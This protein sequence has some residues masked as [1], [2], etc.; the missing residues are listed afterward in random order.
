VVEQRPFKHP[1]APKNWAFFIVFNELVAVA[2]RGLP[3]ASEGLM[4][5]R[6]KLFSFLSINSIRSGRLSRGERPTPGPEPGLPRLGF[7]LKLNESKCFVLS[8]FPSPSIPF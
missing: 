4:Q 6:Y 8:V 7:M 1:E 3:L 5:E 2:Y